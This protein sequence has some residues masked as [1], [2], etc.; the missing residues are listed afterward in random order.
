MW[1]TKNPQTMWLMD[2][3]PTTSKSPS[4]RAWGWNFFPPCTQRDRG[5]NEESARSHGDTFS[6]Q[7][8]QVSHQQ[9]S[10]KGDFLHLSITFPHFPQIGASSK[11]GNVDESDFTKVH[12]D[13]GFATIH[14]SSRRRRAL[15]KGRQEKIQSKDGKG[16]HAGNVTNIH[17]TH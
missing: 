14:L 13:W 8:H 9:H 1:M 16:G 3:I 6:L 17:A 4:S 5:R 12:L 10:D 11:A 15:K 2:E 7:A